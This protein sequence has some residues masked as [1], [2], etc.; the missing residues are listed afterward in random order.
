MRRSTRQTCLPEGRAPGVSVLVLAPL[1]V[2]LLLLGLVTALGGR[3]VPGRAD[4]P[5]PVAAAVTG[6]VPAVATEGDESEVAVPARELRVATANLY[7][8][9]PWAAAR[10]DLVRLLEEADVVGLNEIGPVRAAQLR[11]WLPAEWSLVR[12][13]DASSRWSGMNAVL[14]DE[15]R[16]DRLEEGVVF[17]SPAAMPAYRVDSRWITW[18]R[19]RERSTGIELVHLQTHMDAAVEAAGRP[20]RGAA[21]RISGNARYQRTLLGLVRAFSETAEVVVGGDWNVDARADQRVGYR[22]FPASLLGAQ[23]P[24][25]RLRS[26][27]SLLGTDVPPTRPSHHAQR[28]GRE[29]SSVARRARG[30]LIDYVALWQRPGGATFIDHE[31]L[32]G[33]AS[34]HDPLVA[35]VLLPARTAA[36]QVYPSP[37]ALI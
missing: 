35:T 5:V 1:L 11:R 16:F 26:S 3:L 20:R 23:Q 7:V 17:G 14:V 33:A 31:V 37:G 32:T 6:A 24:E 25:G 9:L 19:L 36:H 2:A 15:S 27:Y 29:R 28:A 4:A 34:D 21:A 8:G 30:R 13:T 18:V 12:P 10:R 22:L